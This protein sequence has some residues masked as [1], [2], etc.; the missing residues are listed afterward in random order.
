MVNDG[1]SF[2]K[3]LALSANSGSPENRIVIRSDI[4]LSMYLRE[5]LCH[6][7]E[8]VEICKITITNN[9]QS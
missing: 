9:E 5:Q 1:V 6:L 2:G 4:R 3:V 8:G 7:P